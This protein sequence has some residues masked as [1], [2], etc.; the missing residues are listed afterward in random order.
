M[1][2]QHL[3]LQPLASGA[4]ICVSGTRAAYFGPGLRLSPHRNATATLVLSPREPFDLERLGPDAPGPRVARSR[5]ALI[6]PGARHHLRAA[7]PLA[8]VYL[9]PLSDDFARLGAL[10]VGA[11]ATRLRSGQGDAWW[12]WNVDELCAHLGVPARGAPDERI[13]RVVRRVD[14]WPQTFPHLRDAADLAGLSPAHFGEWFRRSVGVPFRRYRLWRRMAVVL[15]V[16]SAGGT[17]T[18]A[19]FEAG[20]ASSAHLSAAFRAM[21]GLTPSALVALGASI[22][23]TTAG[24]GAAP[25]G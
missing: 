5:A 15:R 24:G 6:P 21:F 17:L 20:F 16:V 18:A 25:P 10:D 4:R 19:A 9:D 13:A 2:E 7:G 22:E 1:P 11:A 12:A 14:G 8:F 3:H 23:F